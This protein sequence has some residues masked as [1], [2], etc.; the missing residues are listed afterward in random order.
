MGGIAG[1]FSGDALGGMAGK[2][3]FGEDE[4]EPQELKLP[5]ANLTQN[6]SLTVELDG[7]QVAQ[8][9]EQRQERQALRQ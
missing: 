6:I 1:Y 7:T 9:M 5:D 4:Q 3:M 2:W 8:A